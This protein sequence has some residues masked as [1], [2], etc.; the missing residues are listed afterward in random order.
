VHGCAVPLPPDSATRRRVQYARGYLALEM[1]DEARA[2]LD[3]IAARD[4][5][6]PDVQSAR[7]DLYMV[8]KDWNNVIDVGHRLARSHPE[9]EHAWIGWAYALRELN[10]I[11]EARTVLLDAETRHGATSAVLHYNLAC[12]DALLGDLKGARARLARACRMEKRF[13]I[14]SQLDPDL[15]ALRESEES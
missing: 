6:L 4:Q 3:A 1:A 7:L 5:L 13:K 10:R 9:L 14:E 2:E 11:D 12:Y 8:L 15:R